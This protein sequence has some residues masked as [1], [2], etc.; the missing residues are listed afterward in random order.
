MLALA[1]IVPCLMALQLD[2]RTVNDIDVWIKPTKFLVSFV[3]YYATL[4]WAHGFLSPRAQRSR[5][6][7]F[8]VT[9]ALFAGLAEMVW[10]V[11]AAAHGVP[12]H[13]NAVPLWRIAYGV[14]GVGSVFLITAILVQGIL[15]ARERQVA[16]D[17]AVRMGLVAGAVIAFGATLVTAGF[18]SS[19]ANHL[20][21]GAASDLGSLPLIGWSRSGGDLRVAHF[22]ALHTQQALPA[23]GLVLAALGW[24][25]TRAAVL[26]VA[27][28][29][30]ALIAFTFVQALNGQPFI[31]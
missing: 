10:L 15:I 28:A 1:A 23:A 6:G 12:A 5:A 4:A 27:L 29:W 30:L 13:F 22:F 31:A 11:L 7:R 20:V 8:V 3:V 19:Q 9:A 14:A 24:R 21:G 17:P 26:L 2:T 25:Q 16:I 18:L